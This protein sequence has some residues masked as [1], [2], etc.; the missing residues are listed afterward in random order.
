MVESSCVFTPKGR[1]M[2]Q[3]VAAALLWIAAVT[4]FAGA[5]LTDA[6]AARFAG[7]LCMATAVAVTVCIAISRHA[8]LV[9]AAYDAGRETGRAEVRRL[10]GQRV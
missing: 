3:V 7:F 2:V 5:V 4:L 6:D 9:I 10:P 8:D 1:R